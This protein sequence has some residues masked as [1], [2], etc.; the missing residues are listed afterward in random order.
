MAIAGAVIA[1]IGVGVSIDAAQ[2]GKRARDRQS[3]NVASAEASQRAISRRRDIRKQRIKKA[4]IEQSAVNTSVA[5]SSGEFAAVGGL[6]SDFALA[7]GA[8]ASR[9]ATSLRTLNNARS[10]SGASVKG[11]IGSSLVSIGSSI[12]GANQKGVAD[13]LDVD[14]FDDQDL[15]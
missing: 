3:A 12:F 1:A 9:A 13:D 6:A 2:T 4:Q 7:A 11:A 15:A 10:M 8:N 14:I 5:G